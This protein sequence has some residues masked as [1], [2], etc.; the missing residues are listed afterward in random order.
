MVMKEKN[1]RYLTA[2]CFI[3]IG[4]IATW[5]IITLI[6]DYY[7]NY[8]PSI[9]E[10]IYPLGCFLIAISILI[11][12]PILATAGC[13]I[14]AIRDIVYCLKILGVQ[15]SYF[16]PRFLL[17][18][19]WILLISTSL[20]KKSAKQLGLVAG[21]TQAF[22]TITGIIFMIFCNWGIPYFLSNVPD[23]LSIIF[24]SLFRNIPLILGGFLFGLAIST[25]PQDK[26]ITNKTN[27]ASTTTTSKNIETHT[28]RL[29]KLKT[30]LDAGHIT[31]EEF[32]TKKKEISNL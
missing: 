4:L 22:G 28:E 18:L 1:L 9:P 15:F 25:M 23:C 19:F 5:N 13:C 2:G 10:I 14:S 29:A 31:Q 11:S 8:S 30:L 21:A 3:L 12:R 7:Y 27:I 6:N 20:N 24:N 17:L 26:F 16:L 32:E